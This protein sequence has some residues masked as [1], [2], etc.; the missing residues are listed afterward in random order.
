MRRVFLFAALATLAAFAPAAASPRI[1]PQPPAEP[2]GKIV[3]DSRT[4]HVLK[5]ESVTEKGVKFKTL[6]TLKGKPAEAPFAFATL[7]QGQADL[8]REGDTV[9]C[10][11]HG[12]PAKREGEAVALLHVRGRWGIAC[13]PIRWRGEN[14]WFCLSHG[15]LRGTYDGPSETLREHVAAILAGREVTVTA[16]QRPES[17]SRNVGRVWRIKAGLNITDFPLSDESPGFVGWGTGDPKEVEKLVKALDAGKSSYRITAA[18]DLA[19]LGAAARPALPDLRRLLRRDPDFTVAVAAASAVARLDAEDSEAVEAI[20]RRLR[21]DDADERRTAAKAL[22]DLGPRCKSALPGILKSLDDNEQQVRFAAV[23][24]IGE[25]APASPS[26]RKAAEALAALLKSERQSEVRTKAI[27]ALYCFGPDAWVALPVIRE[28]WLARTLNP[29][30]PGLDREEVALLGRFRPPPVELLAAILADKEQDPAARNE[31]ATQLGSLGSRAR[32]ALPALRQVLREPMKRD[33]GHWISPHGHAIDTLLEIDPKGAP[34]LVV[35]VLVE[36]FNQRTDKSPV[37]IVYLG[38]CGGAAKPFLPAIIAKLDP[39]NPFVP[40]AVEPLTRLL[41]PEDRAML[42]QLRRLFAKNEDSATYAEILLRLGCR[43]EVL[44]RITRALKG[45]DDWARLEA[46]RWLWN[47]PEE[48]RDVE[49]ALR[50]ASERATGRERVYLRLTLRRARGLEAG[51]RG[52]ALV[53]L[54]DLLLLHFWDNSSV[55]AVSEVCRQLDADNDT[56]AVLARLLREKDPEIR[57]AAAVALARADPHHPDTVPAMRQLLERYP[58][59][60]WQIQYSL[61]DLGPKAAAV[62][63]AM[64]PFLRTHEDYASRAALRVLRRIDPALAAKSWTAAEASG[65]VPEDL[66]P[67]WDDLA[68]ADP[69]RAY[70]AAWRLGGAGPRAVALMRERL[71]PPPALDPERAASLIADLNSD[72]FDTRERASAEL[73]EGIESAAPALR[74]ALAAEKQPEPRRR[75]EG[76]LDTL[77]RT[78]G[79][80]QRRRLRAVHLLE[81]M[82]DPAGKVLLKKLAQGDPRFALTREAAAALRRLE[83]R[84]NG[85]G[86]ENTR[87]PHHAAPTPAQRSAA[88][89]S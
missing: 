19:D 74:R 75:I 17:H 68:G 38:R 54:G 84:G 12:D 71:R 48:A 5:V 14:D 83:G 18:G 26:A 39:D 59:F 87:S 46:V 51:V 77:R 86:A 36:M 16:R 73:A 63:P 11:L 76:L 2:L 79:P 35:P 1:I 64:L 6:D 80:E 31:A 37:D 42:P 65:A 70:I 58:Q 81:E 52:R 89:Q 82:N 44:D 34:A 7:L 30:A 25:I 49:P 45:D 28:K 41:T 21:A 66:G 4:I 33:F 67:L 29:D 60:F 72:N 57:M 40:L 85:S 50:E 32:A 23:N 78:P 3:A 24:A 88:V 53:A 27:R 62:T 22:A 9:L 8:F 55:P 15:E 47:R 43:E 69:F 61:T 13:S 20:E 56:V 10:I